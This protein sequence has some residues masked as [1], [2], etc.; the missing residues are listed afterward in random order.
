VA[1]R[2]SPRYRFAPA[3]PGEP[4]YGA[5]RPGF[6]AEAV[7][8]DAVAAWIGFMKAR[9]IRRVCCL[10]SPPELASYRPALI[11]QYIEAFGPDRIL[12]APVE[13]YHLCDPLLLETTILPFLDDAVTAGQ[14]MVVHCAAGSG[15]TGQVLAAW[16]VRRRGLSVANALAA[17]RETGRNP[18]EA[19]GPHA[20]QADLDRL[21]EGRARDL[22]R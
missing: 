22:P 3:R 6:G 7:D 8:A 9:G 11:P 17:L 18:C 14:P 5:A 4:I 19:V 12:L 1:T 20:T 2:P 15:R 21:I 13:D 10:L 16:L